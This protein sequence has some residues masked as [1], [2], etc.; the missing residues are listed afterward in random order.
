MSAAVAS[1]STRVRAVAAFTHT[2]PRGVTTARSGV[3]S[4]RTPRS[5]KVV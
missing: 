2:S 4:Q 3:A 1:G 5:A